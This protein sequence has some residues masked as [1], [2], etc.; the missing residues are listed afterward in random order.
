MAISI[1]VGDE[2]IAAAKAE[3]EV[4]EEP[5]PQASLELKIRKTMDGNIMIMD[6]ID[7]DVVIM[8]SKSK[9]LVVAKDNLTEDVYDSQNRLFKFLSKKGL[10]DYSSV[11][12]GNVYGSMECKYISE[13]FNGADPVQTIT[14]GIGKFMNE[15]RPY[16]MYSSRI[17][18]EETARVTD[19]EDTTS[20]GT[21][22]HKSH[23]GVVP[24][25]PS[26]GIYQGFTGTLGLFEETENK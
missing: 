15:E 22:S 12:G 19:P 7:I 4:V 25:D 14:F 1:A 9:V 23:K 16:F 20:L 21:V 26:G 8:P 3:E 24:R 6:H 2:A 17:E 13:T 11:R 5:K 18:D 10:I